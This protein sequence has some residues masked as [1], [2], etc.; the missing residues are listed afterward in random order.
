MDYHW[1]KEMAADATSSEAT[2]TGFVNEP[3][4]SVEQATDLI[5]RLF[6]VA[7]PGAVFSPPVTV[8]DRTLI[9]VSE[10]MVSM[11][12]GFGSGGEGDQAGGGGGGGGFSSGRPVAVVVVD[13]AGVQIKP[14]FDLT[15]VGIAAI[16]ALGALFMAG[17]R[18]RRASR[19]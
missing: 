5:G 18:M 17:R 4:T 14:V 2:P 19:D 7:E 10:V 1:R 3:V 13:G 11:G 9:T 12:A 16:A 6:R 15:K 8:Q